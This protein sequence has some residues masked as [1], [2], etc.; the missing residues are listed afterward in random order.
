[1]KRKI[2]IIG[3]IFFSII[4]VCLLFQMYLEKIISPIKKIDEL[5]PFILIFLC[6]CKII[7]NNGKV[8]ILNKNIHKNNIKIFIALILL[9]IMGIIGNVV[10]RYQEVPAIIADII[11]VIKG[12]LTYIFAYIL[13]EDISFENYHKIINNF[14]RLISG[15]IFTL[16]IAN[17]ALGI[18]PVAEI[19]NG[20]P[21]QQLFFAHPTNLAS[22]S[23]AIIIILTIMQRNYK[24]NFKYIILMSI[25]VV[26][27]QRNKAIMFICVYYMLY[28]FIINKNKRVNFALTTCISVVILYVGSEQ[29]NKYLTNTDWARSALLLKSI[30]VAKDHFPLGSGFATFATWNS[31][32]YYSP[33]YYMYDMNHIYGLSPGY[34]MFVADTF[35]P[36]IIAQFGFFGV[37]IIC[38]IIINMFKNISYCKDK[39]KYLSKISVLVYLLI[40][41]AA[42]TSFMSPVAIILCLI[43]AI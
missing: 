12:F 40:L 29:I 18:F 23:I 28:Y 16:L 11:I 27:T 15:I 41:S 20:I 38:Y 1:M 33:L 32:V 3:F 24:G 36:A 7:K 10:Y 8:R 14:M 25:V 30:E 37:I 2:N 17:Y 5:F 6:F 9:I 35:W 31:G 19:R 39:Y 26:S 13:F 42:E 34:Y 22:Y 21:S 43:M 4:G